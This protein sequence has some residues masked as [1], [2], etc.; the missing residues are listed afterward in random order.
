MLNFSIHPIGKSVTQKARTGPPDGQWGIIRIRRL[1]MDYNFLFWIS[2]GYRHP[3]Y[4]RN[5]FAKG[6][7]PEGVLD[8]KRKTVQRPAT[9]KS[10]YKK[11]KKIG[12]LAL[13][14]VNGNNIR[15]QD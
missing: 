5:A 14:P 12:G 9:V 10:N 1:K 13:L 8:L 15:L 3:G 11:M 6:S 7:A 4:G 2:N